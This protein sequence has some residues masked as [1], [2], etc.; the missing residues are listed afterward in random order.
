MFNG[1]KYEVVALTEIP[2]VKGYRARTLYKAGLRTI[3]D[4]ANIQS[5]EQLLDIMLKDCPFG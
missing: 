3:D 2:Y 1:V 4:V 5:T